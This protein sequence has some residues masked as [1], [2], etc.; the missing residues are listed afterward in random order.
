MG[1]ESPPPG[2]EDLAQ[3]DD[4]WTVRYVRLLP[5]PVP[6]VWE[7]ITRA[8]QLNVWFIPVVEVDARLGG[9]CSFTWGGAESAAEEWTVT[10]YD[11]MKLFQIGREPDREQF[12]RFELEAVDAQTRFTFIDRFNRR[13]SAED[14]ALADANPG[15]ELLELPAGRDTPIRAGILEGYHL[16]LDAFGDFLTRAFAPGEL[17]A[18]SARIVTLANAQDRQPFEGAHQPPSPLALRYYEHIRD[19]C[20]PAEPSERTRE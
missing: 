15:N 4:R 18:A 12:L 8:E 2:T 20:P 5:V 9:R 17:E 16:M 6:R 14:L 1:A 13:M 7:A 19:N 10:H 11:P 3:F